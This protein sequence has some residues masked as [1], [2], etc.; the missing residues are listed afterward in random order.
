V[1]L[2]KEV[3][4]NRSDVRRQASFFREPAREQTAIERLPAVSVAVSVSGTLETRRYGDVA[5]S[6][7]PTSAQAAPAR[8]GP[9]TTAFAEAA[10][11][12]GVW[13]RDGRRALVEALAGDPVGLEQAALGSDDATPSEVDNSLAAPASVVRAH[14]EDTGSATVRLRA[15]LGARATPAT[16]G[17]AGVYDQTGRLLARLTPGAETDVTLAA[18]E[19]ARLTVDVTFEAVT[20]DDDAAA[21]TDLATISEAPRS[22]AVAVPLDEV[23]FGTDDTAPTAGDTT[24]GARVTTKQAGHR[25]GRDTLVVSVLLDAPEPDSQPHDLVEAGVRA[26]GTL[27]SRLTFPVVAKDDRL[28]VRFDAPILFR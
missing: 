27:V 23:V 14:G 6:D 16:V 28:R 18:D 19:E 5:V 12:S 22:E 25:G 20:D 17:E 3:A 15:R 24:L 1:S 8:L 11:L 13:T 9:G 7:G 21:I 10:S 4:A 2:E 26:D